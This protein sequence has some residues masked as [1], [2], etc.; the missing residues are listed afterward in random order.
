MKFGIINAVKKTATIEDL[1]G[2]E[3]ALRRAGLTPGHVDFGML[4]DHVHIVVDEFSLYVPVDEQNYFSIGLHLTAG[5][6]V[7]FAVDR[8][9]ATVDLQMLPPIMWYKNAA[10]VEQ[11][12]ERNEIAR[13]CIAFNDVVLWQW[14]Q[15]P[16][17]GPPKD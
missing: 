13:P 15:P 9:G 16:T 8:R 6:A 17:F 14:P 11:A 12:I 7:I 5:N 2:M 1:P 4:T 10:V 3:Y